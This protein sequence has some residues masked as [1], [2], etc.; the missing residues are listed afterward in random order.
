VEDFAAQLVALPAD[1]TGP[2]LLEHTGLRLW[3]DRRLSVYFTPFADPNP[4]GRVL[5]VGLTPGL[6]QHHTATMAAAGVLRAG[7]SCT[8][9]L[10]AASV[11]SFAGQ[12]RRNLVDQLDGVGVA[13]W[14]DIDSTAELW[15]GAAHLMAGTSSLRHATFRLTAAGPN[16]YS[17][18]PR[19]WSVPQLVAMVD[20]QLSPDLAAVPSA[21]V[22]P[23]G[24]V[25]GEAVERLARAGQ[26]DP[27]RVL[28]GMPHPSPAN[29]H[30]AAQY[31]GVRDRMARR[32]GRWCA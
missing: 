8:E 12:L 3:S 2:E 24:K 32:V 6:H 25:A 17:G 20:Q 11:G 26:V 23:L 7:G 30:R 5:L 28:L 15:N 21:L 19:L 13:E 29:G 31:A 4:A 9:A 18:T 14:L 22:V 16:N 27:E 1:L 10:E